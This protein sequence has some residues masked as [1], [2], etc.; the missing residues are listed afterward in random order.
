M[1][2]LVPGSPAEH[3]GLIAADDTL[4]EINGKSFYHAWTDEV[5]AFLLGLAGGEASVIDPAWQAESDSD[6]DRD[7]DSYYYQ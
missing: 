4:Y 5:A 2:G 3:C 7:N 6:S 1:Q